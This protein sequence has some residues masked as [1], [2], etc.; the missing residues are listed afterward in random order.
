M[1]LCKCVLVRYFSHASLCHYLLAYVFGIF[2]LSVNVSN[3]CA[4]GGRGTPARI[5][6]PDITA[7]DGVIH[8]I[9]GILGVLC[10][11]II[12]ELEARSDLRYKPHGCSI[13]F[14]MYEAISKCV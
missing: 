1:P 10:R 5:T 11:D 6:H 4:Q 3:D 8:G 14:I 13:W 2:L 7:K 9:D 12:Q